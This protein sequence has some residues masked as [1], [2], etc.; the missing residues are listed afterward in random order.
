MKSVGSQLTDLGGL[1]GQQAV[2]DSNTGFPH[3]PQRA[4]QLQ[5]V[6]CPARLLPAVLPGPGPPLRAQLVVL[7]ATGTCFYDDVM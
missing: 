5:C 6:V 2:Q 4:F 3:S 1:E 7:S